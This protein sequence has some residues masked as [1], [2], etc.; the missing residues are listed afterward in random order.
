MGYEAAHRTPTMPFLYGIPKELIVLI[1]FDAICATYTARC[2]PHVCL[3][4][5]GATRL[6]P[7]FR[8]LIGGTLAAAR[9]R[10]AV[11]RSIFTH[12]MR[13]YRRTLYTRMG[14][15]TPLITGPSGRGKELVAQAIA[16][17]CYVPFDLSP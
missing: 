3:F 15:F 6:P 13:R 7:Y 16:L 14:D 9:L 12:D 11:W 2:S 8:Y 17:S 5:S 1:F 10:A 4:L